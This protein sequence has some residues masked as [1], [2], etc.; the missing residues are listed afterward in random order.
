MTT[1]NSTPKTADTKRKT[2]SAYYQT[3]KTHLGGE[4]RSRR[5]YSESLKAK[6]NNK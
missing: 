2:M 1:T 5:A 3:H 4:K 6:E